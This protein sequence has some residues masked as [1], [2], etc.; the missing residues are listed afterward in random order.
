MNNNVAINVPPRKWYHRIK[1][2]LGVT[3]AVC[4]LPAFLIA[5]FFLLRMSPAAMG[6][7]SLNISAPVRGFV[8]ML[9]SLYPFSMMEVF[10]TAAVI[11]LIYYLIKTWMVTAHRRGKLKILSRRLLPVVVAIFYVWSLFC[12]LWTVGYHAP[13]FAEKNEFTGYGITSDNL[14]AVTRIFAHETNRLAPLVSRDDDGRFIEERR[15]MFAESLNIYQNIAKEFPDL[16][17]RLFRPKPMV[18]SWLMSRTGY[19][20]I[21]FALTGESMI[22]TRMPGALMPATVAHEHAHQLGVFAEDEANFVSILACIF[23]NST[24]FAYSGYLRGLMYLMPALHGDDYDAWLEI[25]LGLSEEVMRDW[26]DNYDFWQSQ[27]RV[28]TGVA[29]LD[30]I[31]TTVTV[32]V[33]DTVDAVYDGFLRSNNQELG[34]MSYGACVDLIVEY[35]VTR[36]LI[37]SWEFIVE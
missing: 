5:M 14:A 36:E 6:W 2:P 19:T 17:D 25:S 10:I 16:G 33:S 34:L 15:N 9:S 1:V 3:I 32:A 21:Y 7:A 11:G 26:Q 29:F 31:L 8:G 23:S 22:N 13:G 27:R 28:E 20:G 30:S 12:W 37:E 4:V 18:F 35:F 24:V